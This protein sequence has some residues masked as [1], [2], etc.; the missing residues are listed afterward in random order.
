MAAPSCA[1]PFIRDS[2]T[3]KEGRFDIMVHRAISGSPRVALSKNLRHKLTS[4]L[5]NTIPIGIVDNVANRICQ[6]KSSDF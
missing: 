3:G 2:F 1:A 6:G 4:K 5:L